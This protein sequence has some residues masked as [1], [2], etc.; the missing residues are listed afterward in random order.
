MRRTWGI[1]LISLVSAFALAI[2]IS[3]T[4]RLSVPTGEHVRALIR[5]AEYHEKEERFE[6]AARHYREALGLAQNDVDLHRRYQNV[7]RRIG[8]E[9]DILLEYK[10]LFEKNSRSAPHAYLYARLLKDE[11]LERHMKTALEIDPGFG[12]AHQGLGYYYFDRDRF[13][14]A[15]A[16]LERARALLAPEDTT[17]LRLGTAYLKTAQPEP[18]AAVLEEAKVKFSRDPEPYYT[19]GAMYQMNGDHRLAVREFDEALRRDPKHDRARKARE[20]SLHRLPH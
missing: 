17:W 13:A 3:H 12:W 4:S 14:E 7:M 2:A 1:P 16:H 5:A 19:L 6:N 10:S 11:D 15:I 20:D 8:R 9:K 18:A